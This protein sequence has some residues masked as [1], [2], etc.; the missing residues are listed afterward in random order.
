MTNLLIRMFIK[1]ENNVHSAAVRERY[2]LL[3][4]I[5]GIISNFILF[6]LKL[7][8]GFLTG[9]ISIMAD[10]VNNLS[11]SASSVITLVGFKLSGMPADEEHPYGHA[12]FEYIGGLVVS[13]V[14]LVVG[15]QFLTSSF[16]KVLSPSPVE[17]SLPVFIVLAV[18]IAIKMWQG[19]FNRKIGRRIDSTALMATAVDSRNDVLTTSA[20]LVSAVISYVLDWNL[21][22]YMGMVVA[23]FILYSGVGLIRET[24]NPLLGMAP[25]RELVERIQE[26]IMSYESVIGLHDMMVHNYG[27]DRCFASVHVEFPAKQDIMISHDIIDNMERDFARDMNISMVIHLDPVV[28][29]DPRIDAMQQQVREIAAGIDP[30]LDIHDFRMVEGASHTNLIFDIVVP[31]RFRLS[32]REL[33]REL[34]EAVKT[35]DETYYVVVTIDHSYIMSVE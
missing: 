18:S 29:D 30:V 11:D 19:L 8:I 32:D 14:I 31:P 7:A 16:K 22:G 33:R 5:V 4:G 23:A 12:R 10:A 15:F 20:V 1:D 25:D 6:V 3:A 21:D 24:L 35:L 17:F 9:S 28:T 27:P 34:D 2:G 13:C 26:K